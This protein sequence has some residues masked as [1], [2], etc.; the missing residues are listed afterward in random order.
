MDSFYFFKKY[1]LIYVT[2]L[3]F[4]LIYQ[5]LLSNGVILRNLRN[6]TIPCNTNYNLVIFLLYF[7]CGFKCWFYDIDVYIN[8]KY[9]NNN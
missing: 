8:Y 1:V 5:R 3:R 7:P 2:C 4:L 9:G 6:E